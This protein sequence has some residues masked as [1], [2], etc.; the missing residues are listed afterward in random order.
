M[1]VIGLRVHVAVADG[2]QR[3]DREIEQAQRQRQGVGNVG[4]RLVAEPEQ[5]CEDGV[6]DDED[7]RGAAEEPRPVDR[8]A[9]MIEVAPEAGAEAARF[10]LAKPDRDKMGFTSDPLFSDFY[11]RLSPN[12]PA[13]LTMLA[14]LAGIRVLDER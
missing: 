12:S 3:L 2:R 11:Q 4:D 5:E 6:E 7:E 8:H 14:F 10:D 9:A 13:H 1:P